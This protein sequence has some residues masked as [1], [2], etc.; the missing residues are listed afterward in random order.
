MLKL[1]EDEVPQ[2]EIAERAFQWQ[3]DV[4]SGRRR[5]VG[6]NAHLVEDEKAAKAERL[7]VSPKLEA[8]QVK[9]LKAFKKKRDGKAVSAALA[10]LEKAAGTR[11]NLFPRILAAVESRAT[12]GEVF[13]T[14][15]GVFG[16]HHGR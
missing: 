2:R 15:R 1:I 4:E 16:E 5:I 7:K 12:L 11:E 14:L 10:A 3:K 13:G 9:R 8:E 6:V